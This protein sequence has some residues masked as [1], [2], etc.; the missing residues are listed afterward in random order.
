MAKILKII[1]LDCNGEPY[2]M[3]DH[4]KEKLKALIKHGLTQAEK[5]I[6]ILY[7]YEE[8][9]FKEIGAVLDKPEARITQMYSSLI[10]R[11]RAAM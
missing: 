3:E 8:M 5:I 10:A 1:G 2:I 11:L 4:R 9:T 6:V 7:Y